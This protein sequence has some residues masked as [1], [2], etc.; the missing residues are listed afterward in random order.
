MSKR[1]HFTRGKVIDDP[2]L[3]PARKLGP[4]EVAL[5]ASHV[6]RHQLH[7]VLMSS[8][9]RHHLSEIP[10][11]LRLYGGCALRY[12]ICGSVYE[13]RTITPEADTGF[14]QTILIR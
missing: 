8:A 11:P 14:L 7:S 2:L 4:R 3:P 9:K 5:S 10:E 1:P 12:Y 6:K 13:Y